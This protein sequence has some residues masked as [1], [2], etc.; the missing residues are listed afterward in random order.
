MREERVK[1]GRE[2]NHHNHVLVTMRQITTHAVSS[3]SR[4]CERLSLGADHE[5]ITCGTD[6]VSQVAKRRVCV[7]VYWGEG[8]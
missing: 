8:G 7:C 2:V 6:R 4:L 5:R 1:R 3:I